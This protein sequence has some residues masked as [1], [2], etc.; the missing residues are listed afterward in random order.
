MTRAYLYV[1]NESLTDLANA[2]VRYNLRS[3]NSLNILVLYTTKLLIV[4]PWTADYKER[5]DNYRDMNSPFSTVTF[6]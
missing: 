1:M 2:Y 5:E 4:R 6:H 3:R